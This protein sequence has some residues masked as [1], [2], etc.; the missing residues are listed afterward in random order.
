MEI[1]SERL[2][3]AVRTYGNFFGTDDERLVHGFPCKN[4]K[5]IVYVFA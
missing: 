5:A 1:F 3:L 4:G 2:T